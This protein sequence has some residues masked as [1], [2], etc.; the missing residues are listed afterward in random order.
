MNS[1]LVDRTAKND[2]KIAR[3]KYLMQVFLIFCFMN[4]KKILILQKFLQ[5]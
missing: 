4:Q 2:E 3:N 1:F 5:Q